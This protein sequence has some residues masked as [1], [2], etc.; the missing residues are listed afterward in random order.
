MATTKLKSDI[1]GAVWKILT[2]VGQRIAPGSEIMIVE[3]MKMEIPIIS[4][5]GGVI[6]SI[7]VKE[8]DP[9]SPGQIVAT[10]DS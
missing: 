9:V 8:G 4:E 1:N 6:S 7:D 3:S 5:D 10:L 2:K